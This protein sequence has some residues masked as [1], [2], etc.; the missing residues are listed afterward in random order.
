MWPNLMSLISQWLSM[1]L[2]FLGFPWNW[3]AVNCLASANDEEAIVKY[4][5]KKTNI[6]TLKKV[7]MS[8]KVEKTNWHRLQIAM[9]H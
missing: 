7:N 6:D 1:N 8:K 3:K 9:G 2:D 5:H 4:L